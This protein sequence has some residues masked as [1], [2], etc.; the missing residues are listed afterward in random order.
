M[1]IHSASR[2][3]FGL[4]EVVFST[5]I[6]IVVVGSMVVLGRLSAR[7][8]VIS[9]HRAVAFNLAQD[10]LE[11][12]RQMRDSAWISRSTNRRG[13]ENED[14]LMYLKCDGGTIPVYEKILVTDLYALKDDP[15]QTGLLCLFR[16]PNVNTYLSTTTTDTSS[17]ILRDNQGRTDPGAPLSYKRVIRFE[18]VPN[19]NV[20][21]SIGENTYNGLQF[22]APNTTGDICP[23]ANIESSHAIK[24]VTTVYWRDFEKDWSVS[25]NTILT[26]WRPK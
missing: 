4:L 18:S 11:S 1:K 9:T 21:C 10:G 13:D 25:L 17:V 26:N 6:F 15:D 16:A 8:A 20:A 12:I 2:H 24:V 19:T 7:N 3:G 23:T 5:A 22:L 14:W